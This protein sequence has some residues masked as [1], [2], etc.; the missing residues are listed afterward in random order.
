[1]PSFSAKRSYRRKISSSHCRK[2]GAKTCRKLPG[3]K[4]ARGPVRKFCRKRRNTLR[5]SYRALSEGSSR[6]KH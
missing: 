5:Q 4:Y 1:M 3:C 6:K 2:S